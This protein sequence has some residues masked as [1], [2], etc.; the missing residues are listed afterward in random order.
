MVESAKSL[1]LPVCVKPFL[2]DCGHDGDFQYSLKDFSHVFAA[3]DCSK[4]DD[5]LHEFECLD[6]F[7]KVVCRSK[8][9]DITW[10]QELV[11]HQPAG[12]IGAYGNCGTLVWYKSAAILIRFPKWSKYRQKLIAIST[13]E[14]CGISDVTFEEDGVVKDFEDVIQ[15]YKDVVEEETQQHV[16]LKQLL[17]NEYISQSEELKDKLKQI[18][19]VLRRCDTRDGWDEIAMIKSDLLHLKWCIDQKYSFQSLH[20]SMNEIISVLRS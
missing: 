15:E 8:P 16:L 18:Q 14:K 19:M 7:G 20:Y 4:A 11:C 1:G 5:E 9:E 6:L 17:D 13:G 3:G 2:R 10:C 12:V